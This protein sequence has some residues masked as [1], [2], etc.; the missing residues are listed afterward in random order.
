MSLSLHDL[1]VLI[2][3]RLIPRV[4]GIPILA[5]CEITPQLFIGAQYRRAGKKRLLGMGV[6]ATVN[7]RREFDV[8]PLDLTFAEHCYLP[9]IDDEAPSLEH[10][11]EG[12][13]FIDRM[14]A[15][16]RKVYV[17]CAAGIGRSPTLVAAHLIRNGHDVESAIAQIAVKRPFIFINAAQRAQLRRFADRDRAR[18]VTTGK[19]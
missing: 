5:H 8:R 14:I 6:S 16:G 1:A 13:G 9:T 17:H 18:G 7:L 12:V 4:T 2:H 19:K 10:L 15:D 11:E 3:G